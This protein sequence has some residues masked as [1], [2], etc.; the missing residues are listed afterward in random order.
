MISPEIYI[1]HSDQELL[2]ETAR[3]KWYDRKKQPL[4]LG[5]KADIIEAIVAEDEECINLA[6]Y[7]EITTQQVVDVLKLYYQKPT[8]N[9]Y[10]VGELSITLKSKI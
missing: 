4:T 3:L 8:V 1:G 7:Y 9:F 2:S 6:D 10:G 5:Q